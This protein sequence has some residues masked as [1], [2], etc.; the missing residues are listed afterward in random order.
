MGMSLD[1]Q[2][3]LLSM[4]DVLEP[5]SQE[6]LQTLAQ[7][8]PDISLEE[9]QHL[10]TPQER[11]ERLYFLKKG[12]VRIYRIAEEREV[13]LAMVDEGTVFGEMAL[14]DQHLRES[15]AR[16]EEKST[17]MAMD[18]Q[19]LEDLM[20]E[21][22]KVGLQITRLLT[23][24]LRVYEERLE[25]LTLK[26]VPARLASLL[27]LLAESEGVMSDGK[28]IRIPTRYTHEMLSTMIGTTRVGVTRAFS[29]LQDEGA[30]ELWRRQIH[31]KELETLKRVAEQAAPY[32]EEEA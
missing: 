5:L 32:K 13:T 18:R 24:R 20:L 1:E 14:T 30:V 22:P 31:L 27:L 17:V 2:I 15:F 19:G 8:Y 9:G 10:Y 12:R 21:N 23:E 4:V 7:R 28:Q 3:R 25:A 6:Q 26:Q 11:S 29:R 16:A